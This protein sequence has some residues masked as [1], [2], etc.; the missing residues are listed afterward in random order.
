MST[1]FAGQA[2]EVRWGYHRAASLGPWSLTADA[3]GGD[4]SAEVRSADH[5]R[6]S[7]QPLALVVLRQNGRPLVWPIVSLHIAGDRLT[8]RVGLQE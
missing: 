2:A 4:L 1:V 5:A 7:Q 3:A 6:V 8:G